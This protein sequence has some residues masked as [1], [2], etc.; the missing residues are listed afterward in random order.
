MHH[1]DLKKGSFFG[2]SVKNGLVVWDSLKLGYAILA[3][4]ALG[5]G[6]SPGF[7]DGTVANGLLIYCNSVTASFNSQP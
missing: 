5:L 4:W 3:V 6:V 1:P 2:A 7:Y